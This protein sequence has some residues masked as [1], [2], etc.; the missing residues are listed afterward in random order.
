MIARDAIFKR[1]REAGAEFETAA[2]AFESTAGPGMSADDL[3][4]EFK[5]RFLAVSGQYHF[6]SEPD[7]IGPI[8]SDILKDMKGQ[9]AVAADSAMTLYPG[10]K[11]HLEDLGIMVVSPDPE[12]ARDAAAGISASELA[13]AYSGSLLVTSRTKGDLTASLLPPVHIALT[14][15]TVL[16]AGIREL[17]L[18]L[19]KTGWPRGAALITGP[20]R[21]ADIELSLVTGVHGPQE[22]HAVILDRV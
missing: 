12:N 1:L 15:R 14:P 3:L 17:L 13:V 16:A 21:T 4:N 2:D 7:G 10:L 22:V 9:K 18:F 6:A 8:L 19:D 5:K 11:D 20:S